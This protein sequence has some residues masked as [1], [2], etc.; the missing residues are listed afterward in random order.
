MGAPPHLIKKYTTEYI[1]RL[2]TTI[3]L[4]ITLS[5]PSSL[6]FPFLW[7][8]VTVLDPAV[9]LLLAIQYR[10]LPLYSVV[11][12][13]GGCF[14]L[15]ALA[16]VYY[17][18]TSSALPIISQVFDSAP[19]SNDLQAAGLALTAAFPRSI[20]QNRIGA[21]V[22]SF[23]VIGL[24]QL[25][26]WVCALFNLVDPITR[27]R[28]ELNDP[29]LFAMLDQDTLGDQSGTRMADARKL[30]HKS[31]KRLYIYSESDL[32]CP[33]SAIQASARDAGR[34]GWKVRLERF[35]NS[36]HV[37]H[38]VV[39]RERYWRLVEEALGRGRS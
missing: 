8:P 36:K 37:G 4:L 19:G 16:K 15:C 18:R 24:V 11:Y 10:D 22:T 23:L 30:K 6:F 7:D 26:G 32:V 38:A 1:T 20:T 2:P 12:S 14:S 13:N 3:I 9:Q 31:S 35:E 21:V 27:L 28:N 5:N 17:V 29:T 25:Y 34:K 39:D 33:A